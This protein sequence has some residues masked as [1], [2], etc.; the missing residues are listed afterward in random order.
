MKN[1]LKKIMLLFVITIFT[2]SCESQIPRFEEGEFENLIELIQ[3]NNQYEYF[4]TLL[5][6]PSLAIKVKNTRNLHGQLESIGNAI[7][8]GI[9]K[10]QEIDNKIRKIQESQCDISIL[11]NLMNDLMN[12][13]NYLLNKRLEIEDII[14]VN[15]RNLFDVIGSIDEEKRNYFLLITFWIAKLAII[16]NSQDASSRFNSIKENYIK[17]KNDESISLFDKFECLKKLLTL[18]GKQRNCSTTLRLINLYNESEDPNNLTIQT[19][20]YLQRIYESQ[21]HHLQISINDDD[22][23]TFNQII[24]ATPELVLINNL[25][26]I[27]TIRNDASNEEIKNQMIKLIEKT[28]IFILD[29][30]TGL[31]RRLIGR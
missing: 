18:N 22:L 15:E 16:L 19:N 8:V 24:S 13:S 11:K 25:N 27:E 4:E 7:A 3:N 10:M 5:N 30:Q 29:G 31:L 26:I 6:N 17:L 2:T 1:V 12:E 21:F 20:V 14:A 9:I 23:E 28:K